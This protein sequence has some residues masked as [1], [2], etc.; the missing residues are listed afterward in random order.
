MLRK[1]IVTAVLLFTLTACTTPR[2]PQ[3]IH[4]AAKYNVELGLGYL[5]RGD[6][7]RAKHKL[8]LAEAEAPKDPMVL[9]A[10][11]YF[12]ERAGEPKRAETYFLQAVKLAPHRGA[13]Q[14]NYGTFLCRQGQYHASLE[15]FTAAAT[16]PHY[17]HP[18]LAY[19]NAGQCALKIPNRA[20]AE[21]YF[22]RALA[23]D[24]KQATALLELKKLGYNPKKVVK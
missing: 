22:K 6:M 9:D 14:N 11:G 21:H 4:P 7:A 1:M 15:H 5:Q 24:P 13:I 17:L 3:A 10:L 23:H 20:L 16:D 2:P 12:Y 18:A 19:V 8:L